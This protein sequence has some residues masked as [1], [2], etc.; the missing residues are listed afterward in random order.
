[1]S[2]LREAIEDLPEAVFADLLE[3]EDAYL[4]VLDMPGSTAETVDVSV[5]NGRLLVEARREK[6]IPADFE[7]VSE[8]R[9]LFLD[10]EVPLPPAVAPGDAQ[11]TVER[12]VLELRLPKSTVT[13]SESIPVEDA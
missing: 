13:T 12:G 10:V 7:Y 3:S 5:E 4:L 1:M 6:S 8:E 11:A 2:A 9:S